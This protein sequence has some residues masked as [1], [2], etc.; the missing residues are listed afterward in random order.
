MLAT[1]C[2]LLLFESTHYV[3]TETSWDETGQNWRWGTMILSGFLLS[4]VLDSLIGIVTGEIGG[5]ASATATKDVTLEVEGDNKAG[6]ANHLEGKVD[7]A[8]ARS[9]STTWRIRGGVL[10]GDFLHN[11]CDGFFT[12]AAFRYCGNSRGWSVAAAAV[13]HELAQEVAD[14]VLLTSPYKGQLT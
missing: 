13:I 12:G 8:R 9:M 2:F 3:A 6:V 11:L 14:Y 1:S 4:A 7:T 5:G 10:V